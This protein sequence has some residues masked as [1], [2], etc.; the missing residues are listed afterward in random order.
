MNS[1]QIEAFLTFLRG[2]EQR[3]HMSEA[4]ELE[5]NAITNDIHH[6]LELVEHS[7]S[8]LLELAF[9]LTS[10]R[11]KRRVAKDCMAETAPVL[12][13]VEENRKTIKSLEQLLGEVRR[14]ERS[15][16]NRI[17]TPRRR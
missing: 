2:C 11:K 3:Y 5:A 7:E 4:E 16:E 13:W 12:A 10:A 14:A 9:E 15:V 6:D 17:Y 1:D 8:E